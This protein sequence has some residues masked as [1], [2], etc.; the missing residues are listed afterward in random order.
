[1]KSVVP[2][3]D[4]TFSSVPRGEAVRLAPPFLQ[5][6]LLQAVPPPIQTECPYPETTSQAWERAAEE[7]RRASAGAL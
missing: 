1:M 2:D 4:P 6:A 3:S 5:T 7:R